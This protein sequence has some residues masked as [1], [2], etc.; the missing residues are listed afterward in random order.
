MISRNLFVPDLTFDFVQRFAGIFNFAVVCILRLGLG[1]LSI[2]Q[3]LV[4]SIA[5]SGGFIVIVLSGVFVSLSGGQIVVGLPVRSLC[6][7]Q[8]LL[9]LRLLLGRLPDLLLGIF[10][11]AGLYSERL[12]FVNACDV[13]AAFFRQIRNHGGLCIE[14]THLEEHSCAQCGGG[15]MCQKL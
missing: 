14:R 3:S 8:L 2:A 13:C 15:K 12:T 5:L 6:V 9:R 7:C 11:I 1:C 4:S 10:D